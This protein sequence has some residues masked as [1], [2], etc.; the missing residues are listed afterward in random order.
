MDVDIL[1]LILVNLE[2][3]STHTSD[4]IQSAI[5]HAY[6]TL[7]ELRDEVEKDYSVKE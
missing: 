6:M 2:W 5:Q 7:R 3:A 4:Q 1:D